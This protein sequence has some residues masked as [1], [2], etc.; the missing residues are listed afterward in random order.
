M[1]AYCIIF[2]VLILI[3]SLFNFQTISSLKNLML[4]PIRK[5]GYRNS[6]KPHKHLC[7]NRNIT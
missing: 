1:I 5:G 4:V 7:N 6:V 2:G 3:S